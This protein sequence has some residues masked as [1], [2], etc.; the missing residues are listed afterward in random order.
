MFLNTL[1]NITDPDGFYAELLG[2]HEGLSD[3]DSIALNARLVLILAN[4]IGDRAILTEAL[5]VA[6]KGGAK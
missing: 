6:T 4:H 3:E 2:V 1:P 5:A